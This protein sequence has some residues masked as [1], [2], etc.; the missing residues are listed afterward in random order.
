MQDQLEY[1]KKLVL[2]YWPPLLEILISNENTT[3]DGEH[4]ETHKNQTKRSV[5]VVQGGV[6]VA[7]EIVDGN[8][9]ELNDPQYRHEQWDDNRAF[10]E[11]DRDVILSV[12]ATERSLRTAVV[13]VVIAGTHMNDMS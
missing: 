10:G 8:S 1:S 13:K 11:F 7:C 2:L 3:R 9:D 6:G 4:I 12:V 5:S